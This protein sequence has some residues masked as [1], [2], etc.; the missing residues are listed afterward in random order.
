MTTQSQQQPTP[1]DDAAYA[2]MTAAEK[3][4]YARQFVQPVLET[5]RRS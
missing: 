3:L 2:K 5:G 4:A 1:V